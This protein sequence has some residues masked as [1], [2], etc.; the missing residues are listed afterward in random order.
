MP[1]IG[2]RT[3]NET[4]AGTSAPFWGVVPEVTM[5]D[6]DQARLFT[7][8]GGTRGLFDGIA[9]WADL[10]RIVAGRSETLLAEGGH[11][12]WVEAGGA[13]D[14]AGC[15]TL[16]ARSPLAHSIVREI[17]EGAGRLRWSDLSGID[18]AVR[19]V[20]RPDAGPG[21]YLGFAISLPNGGRPGRDG[22]AGRRPWLFGRA[23]QLLWAIYAGVLM[24]RRSVILLPDALLGQVVWGGVRAAWPRDWRSDLL[25]VLR[26]LCWLHAATLRLDERSWQ[27]RFG[28]QSVCLAHVEDLRITRP[29]ADVCDSACPMR[30]AGTR[31]GHF[32]VQVGLGFLGAL[33]R[34]VTTDNGEGLRTYDF[35]AQPAVDA[36]RELRAEVSVGR[37]D[38]VSLLT[39]LFGPSSWSGLGVTQRRIIDGLIAEVTRTRRGRHSDRQDHAE[40]LVGDLVPG[41]RP[42]SRV[43]CP[44]L[45][46]GGRFVAFGGNGRRPG[47]GYRIVG[48]NGK[49]WLFKLGHHDPTDAQG[50][51]RAV[52]SFLSDLGEVAA[53][54]G[55]VV[56][57]FDPKDGDWFDL[58]QMV[59][60]A[61]TGEGRRRLEALHVRV[62]GPADYLGRLRR[63]FEDR[64]RFASIPGAAPGG[65]SRPGLLDLASRMARAGMTQGELASRLGVSHPFV[66]KVLGGVRP[67][68]TGMRERAEA[69]VAAREACEFDAEAAG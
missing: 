63:Y 28:S 47:M 69:F 68:P 21:A 18:W 11:D 19:L 34:F 33:E 5:V 12:A 44:L 7:A 40:V 49:G 36:G 32:L 22:P 56:A 10:N 20:R 26:S 6:R 27:P 64:G 30:N 51:A 39:K 59:A 66:S 65:P 3:I 45:Q 43:A 14:A 54:I 50:R 42:R 57:G 55:L 25:D 13:Y 60:M 48:V 61:R 2:S 41:A 53:L 8:V 35:M 62:Y 15:P 24:Q 31:H 23:E 67:W 17:A 38:T 46:R 58:K 37:T 52:R 9:G 29:R 4:G 1:R 16:E